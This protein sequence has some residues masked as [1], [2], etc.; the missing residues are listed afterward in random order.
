MKPLQ[1]PTK[2]MRRVDHA[3]KDLPQVSKTVDD[4]EIHV[5]SSRRLKKYIIIE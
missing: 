5:V 3:V 1:E 2:V 4:D